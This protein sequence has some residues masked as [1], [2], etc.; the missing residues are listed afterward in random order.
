MNAILYITDVNA[1]TGFRP[2]TL[3]EIMTG[4]RP[5]TEPADSEGNRVHR[6]SANPGTPTS[7]S[8]GA[9]ARPCSWWISGY[10]IT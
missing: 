10:S 9:C 2:A 1:P 6:P 7:S 3:E 5:G 4:A 8:P